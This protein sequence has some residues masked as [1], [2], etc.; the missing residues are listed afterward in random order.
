[1]DEARPLWATPLQFV[2]ACISYAVGL[3]NV[4]RFPYLCQMYGGGSFLVPYI[5]MLAVEGMPLLYLEL[6]VGQR[7]RQGSIGA[8]RTISPYLSGVGVASVVVSFFLS[9]Y[10]NVINAWAFW[11]LFH[12]FQDPLPWSVCPLNGNRTGYDEECEKASSTQY[13]WYRKT[14]NISPSIQESG[15]VQWEPA[16]CL[17]LAWLLV[18]LCILRGTE[19][20]GK[21]EQLANPKAWIN[22]ATQIFFSLGLGFG[23]LIAFASYNEPSNDCQKHTVIVSIINSSTSIFASVVTFSIYGFKATFNYESCLNKVILLLTNSFDLEDGFLTVSN[24]EEVKSYLASAYPSKYSEVFPQIKNCSLE[25]EL[26]TAVQGTG[27]A[28]IVYT[29]AI[30]NME[31]SQLWSVL[32]FFML[33]MLGIGSMLGNTA[34]ILTPLT[35]SKVISSYLPK[36]A[37]S[38][39]VCLVNCAIGLVFTM[40]AGNYWFDIFNDYAATL[41]LL[42]IVLVETVAV[43]Y[44][45]GLRRFESDLKAMTGHA[46]NWY[47]K[48]M[49]GGVSP[50]LIISLF[51]FYLSDYIITGTLQYQAWD[52]S[53]GQLVTKDYPP[54][55]L[56]IIGLLVA[57]STMCIPLGALGTFIVR[58][59]KRGD[60]AS[61]A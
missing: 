8:W 60:T 29:E 36:E 48:A 59:L 51:V 44:L 43:C 35:D 15:A 32:Y 39:L 56:A 24:L 38:G 5:I 10:Y 20:T 28:F 25:S 33:L 61:V 26:E 58:H 1:M 49:W 50:L 42:L 47:W 45:Y 34:A 52:A 57:S 11:Y 4:W 22:A 30:K 40:E 12:S 6:A 31:V 16:L 3:G 14:L 55:A 53:Q 13:F 17:I 54:Y 2:F 21:M 18:Y 23:S 7:M 9:M 37:I 41:S 27:L 19:S 46:L